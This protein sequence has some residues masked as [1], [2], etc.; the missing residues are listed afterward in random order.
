MVLIRNNKDAAREI[1]IRKN[2][3]TYSD[4]PILNSDMQI[5]DNFHR[6]LSDIDII[7]YLDF[8]DIYDHS[9]EWSRKIRRPTWR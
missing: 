7:T 3:K 1:V 5:V 8:V 2:R 4:T 9:R 6:I